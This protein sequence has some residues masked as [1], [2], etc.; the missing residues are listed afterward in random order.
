MKK[1]E[2]ILL[3]SSLFFILLALPNSQPLDLESWIW[4]SWCP[5]G[6]RVLVQQVEEVMVEVK[7]G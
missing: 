2:K 5:N 6:I 7:P 4:I 3:R 1:K